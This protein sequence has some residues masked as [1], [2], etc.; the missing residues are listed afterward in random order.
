MEKA[1]LACTDAWAKRKRVF[2]SIWWAAPLAGIFVLS[3]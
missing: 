1:Y 3:A 2:K